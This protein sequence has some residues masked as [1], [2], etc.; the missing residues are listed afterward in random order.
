M[1]IPVLCSLQKGLHLTN[2]D[3]PAPVLLPAVVGRRMKRVSRISHD[4]AKRQ[5]GGDELL[6]AVWAARRIKAYS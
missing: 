1:L 6:T 2:H 5:G 3:F 4:R